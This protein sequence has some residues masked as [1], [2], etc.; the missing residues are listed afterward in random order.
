MNMYIYICD[1]IEKDISVIKDLRLDEPMLVDAIIEVILL[2]KPGASAFA[3]VI[4]MRMPCIV[5]ARRRIPRSSI[6][7][8]FPHYGSLR[9]PAPLRDGIKVAA[10]VLCRKVG[11]WRSALRNLTVIEE[12][13]RR[14]VRGAHQAQTQGVNAVVYGVLAPFYR[15]HAKSGD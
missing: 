3:F 1:G 2:L 14:Y 6:S 10:G 15:R 5:C 8:V 7:N 13:D 12:R 9:L 4:A 11:E